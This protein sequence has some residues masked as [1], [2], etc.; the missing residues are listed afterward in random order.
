MDTAEFALLTRLVDGASP[1]E[2]VSA[3]PRPRA[4]EKLLAALRRNH[5]LVP[6]QP[7]LWRGTRLE[8]TFDYAEAL[9][10]DATAAVRRLL[11]ARV[12]LLGMGGIGCVVL[13]HLLAA[14]VRDFT[15]IDFDRVSVSNLNRQF[16]FTP[17]DV[18]ALKVD[19]A[20]RYVR[21]IDPEASVE[22][23]VEP[24]LDAASLAGR[25]V[26]DG[27]PAALLVHGA[28]TPP[29][30]I[31]RIVA[32]AAGTC[33][34]PVV[35][36]GCRA[37]SGSWRAESTPTPAADPPLGEAP[38][39]TALSF[40]P[41]NSIVAD[42]MALDALHLLMGAS[43]PSGGSLAALDFRS[44]TLRRTGGRPCQGSPS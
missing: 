13:P 33:G 11:T 23:L 24:I 43:P 30:R 32:E 28:D 31:D 40:G 27:Q 25:L 4:F 34:V 44:L 1:A 36:G 42:F 19:V 8:K 15:L 37:F 38:P 20:H 17:T 10:L 39:I 21:S 41:I 6:A 12:V 16:L 9:G 2:L 29:G 22:T 3:A 5:F 18:G 26:R 14:G 7:N 35:S